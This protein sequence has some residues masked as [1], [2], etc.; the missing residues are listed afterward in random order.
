MRS[1]EIELAK[2]LD[3]ILKVD[4][5]ELRDL[6]NMIAHD[7]F[8]FEKPDIK[9]PKPKLKLKL[10]SKD[11]DKLKLVGSLPFVLLDKKI[12]PDNKTLVMFAEKN[13]NIKVTSAPSRGRNEIIGTIIAKISEK[14][15]KDISTFATALNKILGKQEKGVIT[16]FFSEWE[17]VIKET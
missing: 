11:K 13:L 6:R 10:E 3:Q 14:N 7:Y 8:Q 9:K 15:K 2:L 16:N 17:K 1:R 4:R 12:F 5:N